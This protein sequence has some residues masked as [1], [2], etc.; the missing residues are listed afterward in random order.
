MSVATHPVSA[1]DY[2]RGAL[3]VTGAIV[4]WS[5]AGVLARWVDVDPWTTL[6]WRSVFAAASLLAYLVWRD[7][8]RWTD[9]FRRLGRVG[10]AMGLCFAASMICF[11]NALALT[12]VAAVLVF[13]AAAPL[14]AAVLAYFFLHERVTRRTA[15]AI[16]LTMLG[17]GLIVSSSGDAG[18]MWGNLISAVM[19]LTYALTVVLAR[20]ERHVP[21]TEATLLGVLVVALVSAPMA[22]FA[23]PAQ[24]MA[25]LAVFGIFQMGLALIMFTTGIRLIPSA[26]AGLISVLEAVLAPIWV[27]LVFREDP[28]TLTLIGG[29]VVIAAVT[30]AATAERR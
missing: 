6:F 14:F 28:G 10:I 4:V 22:K 15:I 21:T 20:M 18:R 24:D 5:T 11:I 7:G 12:T 13:Q 17:V 29:A 19:G 2:R 16:A 30:W 3:L 23:V 9:G 27:W 8:T 1:S 25:L 26:D